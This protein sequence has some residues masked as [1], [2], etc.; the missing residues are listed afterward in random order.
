MDF[1]TATTGNY[2]YQDNFYLVGNV[3]PADS[4][5]DTTAPTLTARQ[6]GPGSTDVALDADVV[7]GFSEAMHPVSLNA[8]SV[9]LAPAAGGAPVAA[10]ITPS[11]DGSAVTLDPSADLA[12]GT[13]YTATVTSAAVDLAG[14]PLAAPESWSFTTAGAP[15]GPGPTDPGP[16]ARPA[17]PGTPSPACAPAPAPAAEPAAGEPRFSL[18]RAQLLI[19]QRIAQAAIRRLNA[20]QER[21]DGGL[22]AGDL[23]G[24]AIGAEDLDPA[25]ATA[26]APASLASP[27]AAAPE[28]VR[29]APRRGG[30]AGTVRLTAAQLLIN[31]RIGQAAVRRANGLAARLA[32]GL[33]GGDIRDGQLTQAKLADRLQVTAAPATPAPAPSRTVVPPRQAPPDPGAV[34][35][36]PAQLRINQRV[37]QA[38]VRR[39]NALVARLEAGITGAEI[40]DG[41]LTAA[42]LAAGVARGGS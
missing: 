34:R 16:G 15:T 23:C 27:E 40:R 6:P 39:A 11:P 28:P 26:V 36:T 17:P 41:S 25:I 31:Q 35:L 2:D 21:L 29:T 18:S 38:A 7:A 24:S 33:T 12:P 42:D 3:V 4:A 9:T 14:N 37:Y 20:V 22:A 1:A 30:Q 8:S 5:A 13:A 32:E 10:T 19:N